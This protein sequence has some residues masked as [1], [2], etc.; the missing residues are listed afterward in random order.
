MIF[1][2]YLPSTGENIQEASLGLQAVTKSLFLELVSPLSP[3][4]RSLLTFVL[5]C[6]MQRQP[7]PI[8]NLV[9]APQLLLSRARQPNAAKPTVTE[10]LLHPNTNLHSKGKM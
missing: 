4:A 2:P 1:A 8:Q 6:T 3:I 9:Y 10:H 5:F 7:W